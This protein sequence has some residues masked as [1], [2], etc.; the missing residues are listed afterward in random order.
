MSETRRLDLD[1]SS[2][3]IVQTILQRHVPGR[4]VFAFGSRTRG[5]AGRRSDLDL[6]VGGTDPLRGETIADLKDDFSESDLPI[7][8]DVIDMVSVDPGFLERI[9]RDLIPVAVCEPLS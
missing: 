5:R 9:E 6:V 8:V 3:H 2:L 1:A 7:F 4:P